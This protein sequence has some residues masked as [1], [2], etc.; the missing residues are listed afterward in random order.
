MTMTGARAL[1][2]AVRDSGVTHLFGL[3]SPEGLYAE[4]KR[5]EVTPITVRDERSGAIM[6]DA[7]ARVSGRAAVCTAIRGPGA[8]NLV[9]GIAEAY[10]S[11]IPVVAVTSDIKTYNVGRHQIQELDHQALFRPIT[12]WT[13]RVDRAGRVSEL[14]RR[15]F[16]LATSGR[17]GPVLLSYPDDVLMQEAEPVDAQPE[18]AE[19]PGFRVAPDP[20]ALTRA[21]DLIASAT[22]PVIVVGSGVLLSHAEPELRQLA[23]LI[24]APVATTPLGKGA[25][26]ESHPLSLGVV[27]AYNSGQL[28]RGAPAGRIIKAADL[29]LLIG[30]KADSVATSE[31]T[32]PPPDTP[33]IRIDID[34]V[35]ATRNYPSALPLIG[36]AKLALAALSVELETRHL[37][38]ERGVVFQEIGEAKRKWREANDRLVNSSQQPIRPERVFSE[39]DRATEPGAIIC[40]DAS[41]S[42]IW[43]LD[44]IELATPGRRFLSPR[45]FAGIGWGLPAAIGAKL[46]APDRQVVC[47]T[48]DG[49]FGY[50]FQEL[51]TAARYGIQLIVIVL[52][53]SSFG[54]QRHAE[55]A[56]YSQTFEADV[57]DVDYAALARVLHCGGIRISDPSEIATA[58]DSALRSDL[59][60]VVDVV[61][62]PDAHPPIAGFDNLQVR[63]LTH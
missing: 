33:M 29:V 47:I 3:D 57:L 40:T 4:L 54:Y 11:S 24:A 35:E 62:D 60:T 59:P 16:R 41:Y 39:V 22:C 8:T 38:V 63:A 51:E 43:A 49:G 42:S 28:G 34:S 12:K 20:R 61:V 7:F 48:G 5:E 9:T 10:A 19:Y 37:P 21:A 56:A 50:V 1:Y 36:D 18:V 23:E 17:P 14:T 2:E 44:L 32:V 25:F 6:A 46:A 58:V 15:G 45:G 52:N 13:T 55:I 26:D 30:S 53:N 31:W 27:S